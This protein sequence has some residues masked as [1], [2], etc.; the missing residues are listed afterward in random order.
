MNIHTRLAFYS[1]ISYYNGLLR[2]YDPVSDIFTVNINQP[3][4]IAIFAINRWFTLC[5]FYLCN[6]ALGSI[7]GLFQCLVDCILINTK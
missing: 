5:Y 7:A 3:F 6:H 4:K 1:G 2:D